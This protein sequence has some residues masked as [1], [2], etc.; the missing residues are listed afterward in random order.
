MTPAIVIFVLYRIIPIVWNFLLSFQDYNLIRDNEWVGLSNYTAMMK[1][2]VFWESLGNTAFYFAFGTPLSIFFALIIAL[3]V[4]EKI[5]GRDVYRTIIFLPYPLSTVAIGIIWKW[6]YDEKVGLINYIL[7]SLNIIDQP[8]AFLESFSWS[9]PS[10]VIT[11]LWQV[12]GF[13]MVI[14][15]TGLQTIPNEL[16]EVAEIDGANTGTKLGKITLPLLKSSIFLCF[17]VGIIQSFTMF[18]L[19]YV[20]TRGG[21]GYSSEILVTYIYKN[22]FEFNRIGYGAA[23]TI[24]LFLMLLLI[25][26]LVNKFTGEE[27]GGERY[28]E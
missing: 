6:L 18:D 1:D 21:P 7:R 22:A 13:Y 12:T 27:A 17:V 15:L 23:M 20:M 3:L 8:I 2:G 25:T 28:Y 16:Y 24:F 19:V 26:F 5:H 10:V 14:L 11:S 4:N 9:L